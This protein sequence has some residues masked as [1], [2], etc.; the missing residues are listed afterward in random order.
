MTSAE[1]PMRDCDTFPLDCHSN[2]C[3]SACAGD[4]ARNMAH[5]PLV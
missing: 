3:A 4:E 1:K 5:G 2:P